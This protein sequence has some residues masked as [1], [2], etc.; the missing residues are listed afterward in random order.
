MCIRDRD[1]GGRPPPP[2]GQDRMTRVVA[3]KTRIVVGVVFIG[4]LIYSMVSQA[5]SA[6]Y[7][8]HPSDVLPL[9]PHSND[10]QRNENVQQ[11]E[12]PTIA[13]RDSLSKRESGVTQT[14]PMRLRMDGIVHQDQAGR[15]CPRARTG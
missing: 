12:P 6:T 5:T 15:D 8:P 10:Q 4:A 7:Q 1:G 11:T 13:E 2:L 9:E 14:S 3:P